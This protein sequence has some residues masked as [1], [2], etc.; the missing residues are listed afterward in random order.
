MKAWQVHGVG[1]PAD[2]MRMVERQLSD[3]GPGQ[4]KI[5]VSAA[6]I[7][8]P[9]VL[10]CR[11]TYPLT[12]PGPFTPGQELAGTV[13]AVG[14]GVDLPVGTRVMGVSDFMNGNGSF[15]GEALAAAGTVLPVPDAMDD[16]A[17]A[18]FWI[19]NMTAWI[20][21]VDRGHLQAGQRLVVLGAAGG[22]GIAAVQLG[23]A[24]GAEVVAVAADESRAEFCRSY[25]ADHTVVC[26]SDTVADGRPLAHALREVTDWHGVDMIFDPVGGAQ[27]TSA[28]GALARDGKHLAIGFASGTWPTVDVQMMTLT[29]TSLVGVLAAG[30]SRDHIDGILQGLTTLQNRGE[31]RGTVLEKVPFDEVPEALTRVAARTTL[32]KCVV[33]ID[34]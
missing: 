21:L 27:G 30:Y 9:D 17:A 25:G 19:P 16:C 31:L 1:E 10:M 14:S 26:R 34:R 20:G 29:N 2:V 7:G 15:A 32:G 13:T 6:G 22:S 3:P 18:G 11:G 5:E 28:M 24:L 8:L 33:E 23:K 12:P 4:V